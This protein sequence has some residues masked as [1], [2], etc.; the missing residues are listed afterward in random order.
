M[1]FVGERR[2][3]LAIERGWRL[4]DGR[5]AGKQLFDALERCGINPRHCQFTNWFE[6][7]GKVAVTRARAQGLAVIALGQKVAD[8]LA[9]RRIECIV[10]VHPA[11]RGR[12]R[13]KHRYAA[14]VRARL[15]KIATPCK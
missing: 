5:L 4:A 9:E 11:A 10:L 7:G 12:I 3:N 2:S 6:R 15:K 14:H 1:L 13:K 8:A